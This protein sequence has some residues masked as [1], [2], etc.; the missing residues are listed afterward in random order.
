M[1]RFGI[2][3]VLQMSGSPGEKQ[4]LDDP[5]WIRARDSLRGKEQD[6]YG[7]FADCVYVTQEFGGEACGW[8]RG[9]VIQLLHRLNEWRP[10]SFEQHPDPDKARYWRNHY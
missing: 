4:S 8:D 10:D 1:S 2:W 6:E 7:G 5:T 9:A 3:L